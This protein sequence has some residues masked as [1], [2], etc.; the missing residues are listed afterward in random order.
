[1]ATPASDAWAQW[2]ATQQVGAGS[3]HELWG[4]GHGLSAEQMQRLCVAAQHWP[5]D[6]TAL[7]ARLQRQVLAEAVAYCVTGAVQ[8]ALGMPTAPRAADVMPPRA[9]ADDDAPARRPTGHLPTA[10]E[11]AAQR[12]TTAPSRAFGT[13]GVHRPTPS[14]APPDTS[15]SVRA[16]AQVRAREL[17]LAVGQPVVVSQR[18]PAQ[19]P[20][21]INSA[22]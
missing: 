11:L 1:M 21:A 22:R 17:V 2:T 5:K 14:A 20:R 15:E 19:S 3:S 6:F 16:A 9:S 8:P 18:R 12:P 7:G 13:P 10:A 4:R